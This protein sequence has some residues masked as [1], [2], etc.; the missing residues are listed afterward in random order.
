[1]CPSGPILLSYKRIGYVGT[2]DRA[3]PLELAFS[4]E[5]GR[6]LSFFLPKI[7]SCHSTQLTSNW[8]INDKRE[9]YTVITIID[10]KLM[11]LL[12]E[13]NLKYF[14]HLIIRRGLPFPEVETLKRGK[15]GRAQPP[16]LLIFSWH[17]ESAANLDA[18]LTDRDSPRPITWTTENAPLVL[19][20]NDHGQAPIN[21]CFLFVYSLTCHEN[22]YI[23]Q[24]VK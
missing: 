19:R 16:D 7:E 18:G 5:V 15:D 17:V 12:T 14:Q 2:V 10:L 22:I 23:Y 3:K 24:K 4:G 6:V 21:N 13:I 20:N 1:M 9:Y 11:I 8:G